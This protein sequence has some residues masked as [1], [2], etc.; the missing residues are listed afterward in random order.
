MMT[1]KQAGR[2][3]A[4]FVPVWVAPAPEVVA[5]ELTRAQLANDH[6]RRLAK[7]EERLCMIIMHWRFE[8][9]DQLAYFSSQ[10]FAKPAEAMG[11][12]LEEFAEDYS[13][14]PDA[15]DPYKTVPMNP[16]A[17][18]FARI[19]NGAYGRLG[20]LYAAIESGNLNDIINR[21]I[22]VGADAAKIE[23]ALRYDQLV[24]AALASSNGRAKGPVKK[25]QAGAQRAQ[26]A[27]AQFAA[28]RSKNPGW[29]GSQIIYEMTKSADG[30]KRYGTEN[31]LKKQFK[32]RLSRTKTGTNGR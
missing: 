20:R 17:P 22:D 19:A 28:L 12:S 14:D 31:T 1:K 13:C 18:E 7:I 10:A 25:K 26:H 9:D 30:L 3:S 23:A 8:L 16:D 21:A 4:M 29:S 32:G 11:I 24:S 5:A 27:E 6:Q 2:K 15:Q